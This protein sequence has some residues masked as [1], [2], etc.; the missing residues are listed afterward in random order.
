LF[1]FLLFLGKGYPDINTLLLL[2]ALEKEGA[3]VL[4][5]VDPNVEGV[6]IA[7]VVKYGSDRLW[8]FHDILAIKSA[9]Y[10]G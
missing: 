10:I 1:S 9:N 3:I 8:N 4:I 7:Y 6:L 2:K 5:L